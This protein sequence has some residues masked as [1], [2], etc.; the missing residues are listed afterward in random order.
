LPTG[1]DVPLR[2]GLE[3]GLKKGC[4]N[5]GDD[6]VPALSRKAWEL[7]GLDEAALDACIAKAAEEFAT[8]DDYL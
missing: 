8:I 5:P 6:H 3:R 1:R 2:R 7:V 4:G